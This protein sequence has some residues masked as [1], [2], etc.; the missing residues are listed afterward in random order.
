MSVSVFRRAGARGLGFFALI[1]LALGLAVGTAFGQEGALRR[2][3]W[4][5]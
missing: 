4:L 1:V 5:P 2:R 3:G